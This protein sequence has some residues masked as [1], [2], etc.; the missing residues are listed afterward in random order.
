L[1]ATVFAAVALSAVGRVAVFDEVFVVAVWAGQGLGDRHKSF[2]SHPLPAMSVCKPK[3]VR[4]GAACDYAQSKKGP[5]TYLFGFE[6]PE[7]A[8]RRKDDRNNLL[9]LSDA[10]WQSPVFLPPDSHEPSR[11]LVHMRFPVTVLPKACAKW[12]ASYRLR[13]QLLMQLISAA[14]AYA[15][16]PGI[17]QLPVK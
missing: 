3:L 7:S 14:S 6:V 10:I 15:A 9:K 13:E 11:L 16:R 4:V 2:Y 1:F 17:V 8:A 12:R 5:I